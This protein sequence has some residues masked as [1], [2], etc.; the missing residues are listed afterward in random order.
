MDDREQVY[1]WLA[2]SDI[3]G[4]M[5]GPPDF[6]EMAVPTWE[7]FQDDYVPHYFDGSQPMAGRSFIIEFQGVA[8]GHINYNTIYPGPTT[9][10]DI[11]MASSQYT[12]R[13]LGTDALITLCQFL[14]AVYQCTQLY[15]AP[16][17]RNRYALLSYRKAGFNQTARIPDWFVADY[18]DT[19]LLM[20][21]TI[22]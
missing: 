13:G 4:S 17:A 6:P 18:E 5:F 22:P 20:C 8:V 9:E 16:S 2:H 3:S 10:L 11:W 1:Q 15:I 7:E 14:R 12:G 21:K 19:V